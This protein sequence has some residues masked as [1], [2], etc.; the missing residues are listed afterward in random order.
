KEAATIV[1]LAFALNILGACAVLAARRRTDAATMGELLVVV[2]YPVV[3]GV[4]L[5]II[6]FGT[7]QNVAEQH[8]PETASGGA[9]DTISAANVQ[10]NTD[11]LTFTAGEETELELKNGDSVDHN[12]SIYEDD[13]A[14]KALFAGQNVGP[15][16]STTY[17]IPPLEK[18]EYFFRCD[19]H[20]TAMIGT[21][22][23]E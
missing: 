16:S 2:T 7:G 13:S 1:A 21:V 4:V 12:F 8:G 15:G 18:G 6:G 14:K 17:T 10:F 5:A 22:T 9:G 11:S 20:P 19:L 3:I 23:V